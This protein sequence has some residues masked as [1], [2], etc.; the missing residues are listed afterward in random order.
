MHL[1]SQLTTKMQCKGKVSRKATCLASWP[2]S[3]GL[4]AGAALRAQFRLCH[5][6]VPSFNDLSEQTA[7]KMPLCALTLTSFN[8]LPFLS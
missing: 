5:T 4:F 2:P 1:D 7:R 3:Q 6:G 8:F